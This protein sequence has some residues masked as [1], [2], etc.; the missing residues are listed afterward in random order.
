MEMIITMARIKLREES[1][2]IS[3]QDLNYGEHLYQRAA[4]KTGTFMSV[5]SSHVFR[6]HVSNGLTNLAACASTT[7]VAQSSIT[8]VDDFPSQLGH[9]TYL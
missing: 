1:Y 2:S 8:E 9:G 3:R 6:E 5:A 7:L 4:D